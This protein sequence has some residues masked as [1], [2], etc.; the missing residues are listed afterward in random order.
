VRFRLR[1]ANTSEVAAHEVRVCDKLPRGFTVVSAPGFQV[2]G[3]TVCKLIGTLQPG[4]RKTLVFTARAG[5]GAPSRVTNTATATARNARRVRARARVSI[6][7]PVIALH[8]TARP[9]VVTRG[10]TVRFRLRVANTSEVA[11]HEVRVCDKQPRGFT[12][13]SAPGFQVRGR[14]VCKLIGTLKPGRSKT[15]V[16]TARAGAGAPSRVTN[17]ATATARNA[18]RVHARARVSIVRPPP[19][20]VT[21]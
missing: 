15:L 16:F 13:A 21:G 2:R 10:S 8:K 17:T 9:S 7:G 6:V 19:P 18:R 20:P 11:A 14:T 5:A 3:R 4:S 1:V 12:V